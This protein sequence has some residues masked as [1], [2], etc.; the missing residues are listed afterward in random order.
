M[1]SKNTK[2]ILYLIVALLLVFFGYD[3]LANN[4]LSENFNIGNKSLNQSTQLND[5]EAENNKGTEV[6]TP[7]VRV[8]DESFV[9]NTLNQL[10][11]GQYLVTRIVDGDTV[12]VRNREGEWKVRYIGIDAP[13]TAH[14]T[15]EVQCYGL[16]AK[17]KN[18]ELVFGKVVRLEK[19]VSDKDRFGRLLRYVYVVEK[20]NVTGEYVDVG[21][22][23]LKLVEGGYARAKAYK[24]DTKMQNVFR[25]AEGVAKSA[26]VGLWG[27]C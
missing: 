4:I 13:E 10:Q 23:N 8:L 22:V 9:Q 11:A 20:D 27:G 12:E 1:S 6:D 2:K 17:L 21:F 5:S 15:E 16:N 3:I 26:G 14:P 25:T 24:P 18:E 7:N 19:D